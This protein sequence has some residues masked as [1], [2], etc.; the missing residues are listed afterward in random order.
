MEHVAGCDGDLGLVLA[1]PRVEV[2]RWVVIE[3][4]H[5]NDPVERADPGHAPNLGKGYDS[6]SALRP[7]RR[8][9]HLLR[10]DDRLHLCVRVGDGVA[11]HVD[12]DVVQLRGE[13][14]GA[15]VVVVGSREV[16]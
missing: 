15:A 10:G 9:G 11:G 4:H 12:V 14:E 3:V 13:R 8:V 16:G 1:E 2:R 7:D 5:D 6:E